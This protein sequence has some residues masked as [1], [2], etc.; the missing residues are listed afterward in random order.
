MK[1][2]LLFLLS[3]FVLNNSI[4]FGENLLD[5]NIENKAFCNG[6]KIN[7]EVYWA[8]INLGYMTMEV[9]EANFQEREVYHII[10]KMNTYP[11]FDGFF[12]IRDV[13]ESYID[14]KG[15]FSWKFVK[16]VQE[17]KRNFTKTLIFH[18]DKGIAIYEGKEVEIP[19]YCQDIISTYYYLRTFPLKLG[20]N[21]LVD[22]CDGGDNYTLNI[23]ITKSEKITTPGGEFQTLKLEP[24]V[25]KGE[26][27]K[28]A[29][30]MWVTDDVYKI[31]VRIKSKI[32]L[33]SVTANFTSFGENGEET[34]KNN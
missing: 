1:R 24:T 6:E 20:E 26:K 29:L 15:L 13:Y 9:K 30:T 7:F 23:K 8:G 22:V 32:P 21:Y 12:K 19:Q 27:A 14:K 33:G 28:G 18:Q 2:I 16:Y 31:P 25:L 10:T 11:F 4:L 3:F 34:F 5:R 17:G